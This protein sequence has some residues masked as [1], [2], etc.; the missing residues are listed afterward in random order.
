MHP[1]QCGKCPVCILILYHASAKAGAEEDDL[2]MIGEWD[3]NY[4][5]RRLRWMDDAGQ[6]DISPQHARPAVLKD[7]FIAGAG[8][9]NG[10]DNGADRTSEEDVLF[11]FKGTKSALPRNYSEER[12]K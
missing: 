7:H 1:L 11:R 4:T 5:P 9:G 3:F 6:Y 12:K 8:A 10:A 2:I